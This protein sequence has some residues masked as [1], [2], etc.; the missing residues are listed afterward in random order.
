MK[1]ESGIVLFLLLLPLKMDAQIKGVVISTETRIPVRDIVVTTDKGERSVTAWDGTFLLRDTSFHELSMGNVHYERRVMYREEL[2]DTIELIPKLNAL[3]EV[4][5]I[6]HARKG[7]E[8][9]RRF[10]VEKEELK[11]IDRA[12]PNSGTFSVG[13]LARKRNKKRIER[14]NKIVRNY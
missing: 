5:V 8:F 7:A 2:T 10:S 14:M 3:G 1:Y 4:V 11:A 13:E 9:N 12:S 6:G